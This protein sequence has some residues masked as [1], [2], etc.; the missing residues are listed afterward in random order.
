MSKGFKIVL[1]LLVLVVLIFVHYGISRNCATGSGACEDRFLCR[2]KVVKTQ[3]EAEREMRERGDIGI[4]G[5][6]AVT[7]CV[8]VY[9]F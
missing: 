1:T 9:T 6:Q 7:E 2:E 5:A 8:P 3:E 4:G